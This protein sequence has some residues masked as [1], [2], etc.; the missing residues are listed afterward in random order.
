MA[1]HRLCAGRGGVF[2]LKGVTVGNGS[3][4]GA[5]AVVTWSL[6]VLPQAVT[7]SN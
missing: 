6:S 4:V 5:G 7:F 3:I 2:M 1:Y